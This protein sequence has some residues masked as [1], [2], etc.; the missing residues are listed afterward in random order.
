VAKIVE[1]TTNTNPNIRLK[2]LQLLGK[3]TEVGLF[4]EQI[5]VK[6]APASDAELDARIKEKLGKFMGVIDV[7]D[8]YTEPEKLDTSGESGAEIDEN[9]TDIGENPDQP[10]QTGA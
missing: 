7:V 5:Q 9:V 2:A 6:T 8:V 3:V 4:T 1:E 10:D